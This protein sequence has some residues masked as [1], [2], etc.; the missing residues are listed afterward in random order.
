MLRISHFTK[1]ILD[2]TPLCRIECKIIGEFCG[3]DTNLLPGDVFVEHQKAGRTF[4]KR[5]NGL[6]FSIGSNYNVLL[7]KIK[8][9]TPKSYIVEYIRS[10]II[11]DTHDSVLY[12]FEIEQEEHKNKCKRVFPLRRK[13]KYL[14][15]TLGGL[16]HKNTYYIFDGSAEIIQRNG[17]F[18]IS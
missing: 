13:F 16:L 2:I 1:S 17:N 12:K 3:M 14:R 15:D 6:Y 11:V 5:D 8:K 10:L 9:R 4:F 7:W 18:I